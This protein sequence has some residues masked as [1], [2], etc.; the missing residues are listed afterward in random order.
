MENN[1]PNRYFHKLEEEMSNLI[2]CSLS[3]AYFYDQ[4]SVFLYFL[5]E[6]FLPHHPMNFYSLEK[7]EYLTKS[8]DSFSNFSQKSIVFPI[9]SNF[10]ITEPNCQYLS[11]PILNQRSK[12]LSHSCRGARY[13]KFETYILG[14]FKLKSSR[15]LNQIMQMRY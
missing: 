15:T 14:R 6:T 8:L 4:M 1:S 2:S 11:H 3:C 10:V 12:L 7:V 5:L 9:I 13:H